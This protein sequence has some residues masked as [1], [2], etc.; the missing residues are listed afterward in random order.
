MKTKLILIILFVLTSIAAFA[1]L[2]VPDTELGSPF[3]AVVDGLEIREDAA[4]DAKVTGTLP[5]GKH[6]NFRE[7]PTS[8]AWVFIDDS[9]AG[10]RGWVLSS[11][12]YFGKERETDDDTWYADNLAYAKEQLALN[13]GVYDRAD[14]SAD[15]GAEETGRPRISPESTYSKILKWLIFALIALS[16]LTAWMPVLPQPLKNNSLKYLSGA[17]VVEI[18]YAI[19]YTAFNSYSDNDVFEMFI[20]GG[21]QIFAMLMSRTYKNLEPKAGY[22]IS[23]AGMVAVLI[24]IFCTRGVGFVLGSL[25]GGI[26][27]LAVGAVVL[28]VIYAFFKDG[29]GSSGGSR[30]GSDSSSDSASQSRSCSRCRHYRWNLTC[31]YSDNPNP[32]DC[33]HYRD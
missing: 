17:G 27:N 2:N 11:G 13:P 31:P 32:Y 19:N 29:I 16:A 21:V 5:V 6:L 30:S 10:I 25:L 18:L 33:Q 20:L 26:L 23:A 28:I 4:L 22:Y 9:D 15:C 7:H 1:G 8:D 3:T 24:S 12:G 14:Y